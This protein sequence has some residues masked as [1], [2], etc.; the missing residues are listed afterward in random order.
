[1]IPARSAS[2]YR[3][4]NAT[5]PA[6]SIARCRVIR[7]RL[8]PCSGQFRCPPEQSIRER[9]LVLIR[10][11]ISASL[12]ATRTGSDTARFCRKHFRSV[13]RS[14]SDR[15]RS[16]EDALVHADG[17]SRSNQDL[18]REYDGV[19]SAQRPVAVILALRP[20]H[21][22]DCNCVRNGVHCGYRRRPL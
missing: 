6:R 13:P 16:L 21:L 3:R 8:L 20:D 2:P 17:G 4:T 15:I 22:D 1:M 19:Y 14:S 5:D 18:S 7:W 11:V 12:R 9:L 10:S